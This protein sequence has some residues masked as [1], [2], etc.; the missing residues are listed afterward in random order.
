MTT[1]Q[2]IALLFPLAAGSGA[3]LTAF[4]AKKV[5]VDRPVPADSRI[6]DEVVEEIVDLAR[7]SPSSTA[8]EMTSRRLRFRPIG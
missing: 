3:L 7:S 2:A 8:R 5:W 6:P 4:I 1:H